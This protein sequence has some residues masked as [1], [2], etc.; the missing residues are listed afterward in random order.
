MIRV[1][2]E[3]IRTWSALWRG[4]AG[5]FNEELSLAARVKTQLGKACGE[6]ESDIERVMEDMAL[7][8][9][10]ELGQLIA[11]VEADLP[12]H[13]RGTRVGIS[14]SAAFPTPN[15]SRVPLGELPSIPDELLRSLAKATSLAVGK[16]MGKKLVEVLREKLLAS[17]AE[18]AGSGVARK[19][20]QVAVEKA[21]TEV[22]QGAGKVA[23][24]SIAHGTW[25]PTGC[26]S[27]FPSTSSTSSRR[28]TV[29]G[30]R[31]RRLLP[32]GCDGRRKWPLVTAHSSSS[33]RCSPCVTPSGSSGRRSWIDVPKDGRCCEAATSR[34][35]RLPHVCRSAHGGS[36][37][38]LDVRRTLLVTGATKVGKTRWI[39]EA[40]LGTPLLRS[41]ELK[42]PLV[43]D[44]TH[45]APPR[46]AVQRLEDEDSSAEN[47]T[48]QALAE[49]I[50]VL[51]EQGDTGWYRVRWTTP[52]LAPGASV[53]ERPLEH[54]AAALPR[55]PDV[56]AVLLPRYGLDRQLAVELTAAFSELRDLR[57]A[58]IHIMAGHGSDPAPTLPLDLVRFLERPLGPRSHLLRFGP[59]LLE[60]IRARTATRVR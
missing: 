47:I 21:A 15:V 49:L 16:P 1:L 57:P 52:L 38:M 19:L 22:S 43:F 3:E 12:P 39:N 6:L 2:D 37:R 60:G 24:G 55:P 17:A 23:L 28:S 40:V 14:S 5:L 54:L 25:S 10:E 56:V 26:S 35:A 13:F 41:T 18:K 45:G 34:Q 8:V 11:R 51:S 9:Q 4:A 48:E 42:V 7:G 44:M 32:P 31:P 59:P 36:R 33:A 46:C 30:P 53:H 20:G 29:R 58:P 27:R 50:D